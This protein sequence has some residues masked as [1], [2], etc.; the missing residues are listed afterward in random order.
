PGAFVKIVV[1]VRKQDDHGLVVRIDTFL[2]DLYR[3]LDPDCNVGVWTP[4]ESVDEILQILLILRRSDLK[5]SLLPLYLVRI[6]NNS[7]L[8]ALGRQH[9]DEHLHRLVAD[10]IRVARLHGVTYIDNEH[11]IDA[12]AWLTALR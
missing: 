3:F 7:Y 5:Q 4:V 11:R 6:G 2:Q 12:G 9:V 8:I 10:F 1:A